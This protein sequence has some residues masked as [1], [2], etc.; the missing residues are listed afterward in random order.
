MPKELL[1][2]DFSVIVIY[3]SADTF[4]L[5]IKVKV[6]ELLFVVYLWHNTNH[7]VLC[8]LVCKAMSDQILLWAP[9][10]LHFPIVL[11]A[12]EH[13]HRKYGCLTKN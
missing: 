2:Y 8:I 13:W 4:S 9:K 1:L 11:S 7:T 12:T 3:C 6:S 10:D 5:A